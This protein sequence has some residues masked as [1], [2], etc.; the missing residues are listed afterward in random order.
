MAV[1]P[2]AVLAIRKTGRRQFRGM[3]LTN[4]RDYFY[5]IATAKLMAVQ[6]LESCRPP[7]GM[8]NSRPKE[9]CQKLLCQ[10]LQTVGNLS[11]VDLTDHFPPT[12]HDVTATAAVIAQQLRAAKW[13][14]PAN[15]DVRGVIRFTLPFIQTDVQNSLLPPGYCHCSAVCRAGVIPNAT[16]GYWA[17][18]SLLF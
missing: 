11:N 9:V 5:D 18:D 13:I 15:D 7:P 10:C 16:R 4:S 1:E 3:R 8:S 2:G 17:R 14:G 12:Q 6:E